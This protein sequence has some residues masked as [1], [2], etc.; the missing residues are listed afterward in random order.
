MEELVRTGLTSLLGS[1]TL[2]MN[3]RDLSWEDHIELVAILFRCYLYSLV[4]RKRQIRGRLENGLKRYL[5]ATSV[6]ANSRR[7][8]RHW[9]DYF[10]RALCNPAVGLYL[11]SNEVKSNFYEWL[12]KGSGKPGIQLTDVFCFHDCEILLLDGYTCLSTGVS[13]AESVPSWGEAVFHAPFVVVPFQFFKLLHNEYKTLKLKDPHALLSSGDLLPTL[14]SGF[15]QVILY[16]INDAGLITRFMRSLPR[17]AHLS[18]PSDFF[19]SLV[20][21]LH[22]AHKVLD[23]F[24]FQSCLLEWFLT[25]VLREHLEKEL[26]P[27]KNVWSIWNWLVSS[28]STMDSFRFVVNELLEHKR[29]DLE[30]TVLEVTSSQIADLSFSPAF[31]EDLKA[32]RIYE[33]YLLAWIVNERKALVEGE[34]GL[35]RWTGPKYGKR[36]SK[37]AREH[38]RTIHMAERKRWQAQER[39]GRPITRDMSLEIKP[40]CR[41]SKKAKKAS[42]ATEG[43]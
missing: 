19:Q 35:H 40:R 37:N 11:Q 27:G 1:N 14:L 4:A 17:G 7:I 34:D 43:D 25:V 41:S 32:L 10:L 6:A 36:S 42:L 5:I 20:K 30:F 38:I 33:Q 24:L 26:P 9:E 16:F 12:K 21:R 2:L 22:L 15:L 39:E 23:H 28:F 29:G 3:S 8:G 13:S 18:V 31:A